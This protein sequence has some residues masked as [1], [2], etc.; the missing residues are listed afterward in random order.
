MLCVCVLN[1]NIYIFKDN[2]QANSKRKETCLF[3]EVGCA[4]KVTLSNKFVWSVFTNMIII[5]KIKIE[6]YQQAI[7]TSYVRN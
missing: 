1:M 7:I 6:K 4:F 2:K 3:S 5:E